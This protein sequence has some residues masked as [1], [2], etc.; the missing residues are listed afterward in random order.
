VSVHLNRARRRL[1]AELG[2]DYPLA[3]DDGEGRA[4]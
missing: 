3:S 4:S 2:R 1:I